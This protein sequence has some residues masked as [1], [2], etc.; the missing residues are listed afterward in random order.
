MA[1]S[2]NPYPVKILMRMDYGVDP[3]T[4]KDVVKT[5][6]IPKVR[7]GASNED[8]YGTAF[9]CATLL[10]KPLIAAEKVDVAMLYEV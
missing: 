10:E 6:T 9:D 3:I 7:T 1:I 2:E 5:L 8:M 4:G